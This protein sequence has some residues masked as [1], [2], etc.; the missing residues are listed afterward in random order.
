MFCILRE[1]AAPCLIQVKWAL[2]YIKA[3][4]ASGRVVAF[5]SLVSR[6]RSGTKLIFV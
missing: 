1:G 3:A 5:G 4:A 6:A 2:L